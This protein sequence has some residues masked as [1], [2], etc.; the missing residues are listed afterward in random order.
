M[1]RRRT[2]AV[3]VACAA[4]L[5]AGV[6]VWNSWH[7]IAYERADAGEFQPGLRREMFEKLAIYEKRHKSLPGQKFWAAD[8][9][10]F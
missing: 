4:L 3:V 5:L 6:T 1:K 10:C 9:V 7:W 8:Q 2:I